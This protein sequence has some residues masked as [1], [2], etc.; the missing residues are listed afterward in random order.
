M[1]GP[2]RRHARVFIAVLVALLAVLGA[3][4]FV[5]DPFLA[6]RVVAIDALRPYR[7]KLHSRIAKAEILGH[8]DCQVVILGTSRAQIA[9]DPDHPAW[10]APACNLAL[11]GMGVPELLG[12]LERVIRE[13]EVRELV[14]AL[15]IHSSAGDAALHEDFARSRFD[16]RL[17][18]VE[19]HGGLLFGEDATRA[20]LGLVSDFF[21][22]RVSPYSERGFTNPA[23]RGR[24]ADRESFLW[25]LERTIGALR[26]PLR[27]RSGDETALLSRLAADIRT[28]QARGIAVTL[29][30]LPVHAIFLETLQRFGKWPN[31][32]RAR[33]TFMRS[34]TPEGGEP[35]VPVWDFTSY[36]G[37]AAEGV[38]AAG[39]AREMRWHWDAVHVKRELGDEVIAQIRSAAM[40][41]HLSPGVRLTLDSLGAE[42]ER[43]HQEREDYLRAH[44]AELALID[45][46]SGDGGLLDKDFATGEKQP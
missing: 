24:P 13:P 23:L 1:A 43:L 6:Y 12:V 10:G 25:A 33:E 2:A 27:E 5:L 30:I 21:R 34:L 39:A 42:S 45:E 20:S 16:D 28:A 19:Y 4:N 32:E 3:C 41:S 8:E 37:P 22:G 15:D 9:L 35:L 18:L 40:P 14:I 44:G 7:D 31:R 38:P 29:V 46:A 17:Q 26:A 11:T 36:L